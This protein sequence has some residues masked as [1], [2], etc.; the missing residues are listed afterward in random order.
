MTMVP[1]VRV[2]FLMSEVPLKAGAAMSCASARSC[3]LLF[4]VYDSSCDV[5][6]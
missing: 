1:G 6:S 5:G 4:I 2:V 3:K